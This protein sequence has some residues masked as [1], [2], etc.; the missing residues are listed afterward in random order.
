MNRKE[1]EAKFREL[2]RQAEEF[3]ARPGTDKRFFPMSDVRRGRLITVGMYD[4]KSKKYALGDLL[5]HNIEQV[6]GDIE[7]MIT[8]PGPTKRFPNVA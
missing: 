6:L 8:N 3:N 1:A 7:D 4:D 5:A 2:V